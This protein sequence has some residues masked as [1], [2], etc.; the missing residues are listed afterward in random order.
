[1]PSDRH[2]L[3]PFGTIRQLMEM[4]LGLGERYGTG[5]HLY[6]PYGDPR[7][8]QGS[9]RCRA[10]QRIDANRSDSE[11]GVRFNTSDT[12]RGMK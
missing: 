3:T 11:D 4:C 6:A 8:V 9:R 10:R 5:I 12:S 7:F 2:R 1:M